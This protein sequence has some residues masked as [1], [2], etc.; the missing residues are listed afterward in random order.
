MSDSTPLQNEKYALDNLEMPTQNMAKTVWKIFRKV[1]KMSSQT[2]SVLNGA[3]GDK[4]QDYSFLQPL[5]IKMNFYHRQSAIVLDKES[6][7]Q[8]SNYSYNKK[9]ASNKV[10]ILIHGLVYNES[11]W[12]FKDRSDYGKKL[13]DDFGCTPF[14]LRYNTGL[15]ISDNGQ[16]LA[17][18]L[19]KL[20]KNYPQEIQEIH[21]ICHSMGGLLM[22]SAAYY[23]KEKGL[24]WVEKVENVF[25]LGT[26][27]LGSFFERFANVTTNILEHVPNWQTRLVGKIINLRSAGIKDLR[28]GYLMEEDWKDKHPDAFLKN[29]KNEVPKLEN[30]RYFIIS[31][32][33]TK[34]ETHW[35]NYFFGD[36]L[37]STKS[38]NAHFIT[39]EKIGTESTNSFQFATTHHFKLLKMQE[40]YEKIKFWIAQQQ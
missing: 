24:K 30:V 7:K 35:I 25:L 28:Y 31:G 10:C 21:F 23:A 33:L 4:F 18:L 26:P 27:H 17:L 15:H 3:V 29:T 9:P 16:E 12:Q 2:V 39:L 6:L 19:E 11:A 32:R 22:H 14:Y 8:R 20:Y 5:N 38:A 13:E 40:V 34:E 1:K 36:I 37:V